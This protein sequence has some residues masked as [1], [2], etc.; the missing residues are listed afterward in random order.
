MPK[1]IEVDKGDF[2]AF[3]YDGDIAATPTPGWR[4]L[5]AEPLSPADFVARW[6]PSQDLLLLLVAWYC[7]EN[8]PTAFLDA[9]SNIGTDAIRVAKLARLMKQR[10][11]IVAFEP[12]INSALLPYTLK[13][14]D[15]DEIVFEEMCVSN[16]DKPTILFGEHGTSVN[17]R[18]VNR[19]PNTEGFCKIVYSTTIDAYL[20]RLPDLSPIM[21]IDTQ[22]AEWLIWRG[23][24]KTVAVRH[25]ALVMEFT[26]WALQPFVL[27]TKFLDELAGHFY[28]FDLGHDRNRFLPINNFDDFLQRN[29]QAPFWT[30]ILCVSRLLPSVSRLI[31][32]IA[33]AY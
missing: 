8:I 22:G 24:Q 25:T 31:N 9:G 5:P 1:I 26:P 7:A 14:N 13:L 17:N 4:M 29:G 21:K 11:A 33:L 27:P 10:L 28:L 23:M 30:D 18:I 12:G 32:R 15:L 2:R 16:S 6:Q 19:Q 3:V 20:N